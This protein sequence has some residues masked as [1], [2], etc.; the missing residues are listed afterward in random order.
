MAVVETNLVLVVAVVLVVIELTMHPK[1]LVDLVDQ[2][3]ER[4]Q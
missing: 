2:L 1:L 3:K 4:L